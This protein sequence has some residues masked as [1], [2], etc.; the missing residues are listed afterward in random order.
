MKKS[1]LLIALFLSFALI[2]SACG[3]AAD[4]MGSEVSP[5]WGDVNGSADSD[6]LKE[7]P[8]YGEVGSDIYT[9]ENNKIIRSASLT[10]QSTEFD[11]AIEALN[12]LTEQY[13]GYYESAEV[14]GGG[15]FDKYAARTAYFVV[16][17]PKEQFT[18]F[19]NGTGGIGHIYSIS[20]STEDV[21]EVYYDTEAR[22]QTLTV[23][24]DRLLALLEEA[25]KMEDILYLEDALAEVQYQI[26][27]HTATLRKYDSL[28]D[29]STFKI[30]LNEVREIVE[31]PGVKESFGSRLLV[32]LKTGFSDFLEGMQ[33]FILWFAR[34]LMGIIIFAAAA[35]AVILLGR[36]HMKKRSAKKKQSN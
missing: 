8:T 15:Y 33:S 21:G 13:D 2:L 22:L 36:V 16:R 26:D 23:K 35:V 19:K 25:E 12:K 18:A 4:S 14:S 6:S 24:R 28:I 17:V 7:F 32:S 3:G 27:S 31:E 11:A 29:Y 9:D 10:I 20:E 1:S 5:D 30:H 34:N